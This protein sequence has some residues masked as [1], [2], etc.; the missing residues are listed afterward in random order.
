MN[1]QKN[2][3]D[4]DIIYANNGIKRQPTFD[5]D[6]E[7][8]ERESSASIKRLLNSEQRISDLINFIT[9]SS[10]VRTWR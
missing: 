1:E 3:I 8:R 10:V 7:R 6:K 2:S 5:E 4:P 9:R